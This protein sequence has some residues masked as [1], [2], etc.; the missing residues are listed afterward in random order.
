[1]NYDLVSSDDHIDL[2]YVPRDLWQSRLPAELREAGPKVVDTP[3]GPVWM[4]E[5][6]PWGIWGSKRADGRK[7][8]FDDLGISEEAEPG[9]WRAASARY[10]LED[11]DR[12][13]IHAQVMYNFLDWS[14]TDQRLKAEC[15][16]AFNRWLSEDL[17]AA[18]RNRL[19]GLATLP[20][21]D[22]ALTLAEL[23]RVPKLQLRGA[24][25]EVFGAVKAIYDP[26]WEPVWSAAEDAGIVMHVHIGGGTHSFPKGYGHAPWILPARAAVGCMQLDEILISV[27]FSGILT[28]HPKLKLVLGE[29]S[30]GWIPFV[31]DRMRFEK[32]TYA[33][34]KEL[35]DDPVGQFHRQMM[36]T[37]Q[38]DR[39][40]VKLIPELGED[41]VMWA[42]D[43]PHAD[44]S[45]PHSREAVADIFKG[46]DEGLIR[47]AVD[48]N[49]RRV[50]HIV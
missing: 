47:K 1:M 29:S 9:V 24:I 39:L 21:G 8:V 27:V 3:T 42:A 4:R 14:F 30:I 49:A 44:G 10:R 34:I 40:G 45:F 35:P 50:Y 16:T 48:S 33:H 38:E 26:C 28:R 17:C 18:D 46:M 6:T 22:P 5:G 15:L 11:M 12:D 36:A 41:N 32:K 25:F 31:L 43:Y 2:C 19:V 37:F 23:E 20:T 13:G 7:V